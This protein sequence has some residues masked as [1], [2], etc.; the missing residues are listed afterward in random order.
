MKRITTKYFTESFSPKHMAVATVIQGESFWMDTM[1]C[2]GNQYYEK[3][4]GEIPPSNPA[5]GPVY[6]KGAEPG[7]VLCV[8]IQ[9]IEIGEFGIIESVAGK[10]CLGKI[11]EKD[12]FR[13]YPLKRDGFHIGE[14]ELSTSPMVGVIG[15]APEEGEISTLL[16]GSHGGNLDCRLIDSGSIV[17]LPV[18]VEGALL[19]VGDLHG[20]MADGEVG[21]SGLETYGSVCLRTTV[22]KGLRLPGPMVYANS[23]WYL[24][25]S[26]ESLDEAA[27]KVCMGL[28]EILIS[29]EEWDEKETVRILNL[30]GNLEICQAVNPLKTVRIG[31]PEK[32]MK[33]F[34]E[35]CNLSRK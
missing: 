20:L 22:I 4:S 6:I 10:G 31:I 21:Y 7:D 13:M 2:F 14:W 1:D 27:E 28:W 33:R 15:V 26:A 8:E 3:T 34:S 17:F 35:K 25:A 12:S 24:L 19:S 32:Y 29:Y 30:I 18:F 5:T 9:K 16:P 11:V 23:T